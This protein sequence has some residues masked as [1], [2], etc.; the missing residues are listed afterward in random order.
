MH[1]NAKSQD[2]EKEQFPL[3]KFSLEEKKQTTKGK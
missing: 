1:F 2:E 3:N